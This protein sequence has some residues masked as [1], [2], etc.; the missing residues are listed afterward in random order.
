MGKGLS[1]LEIS[2][3]K[4]D[5]INYAIFIKYYLYAMHFF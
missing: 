2:G 4:T 5:H 1:D 3:S